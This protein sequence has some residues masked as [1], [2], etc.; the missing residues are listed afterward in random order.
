MKAWIFPGQGAQ[1]IGMGEALFAAFPD[2]TAA[3]DAVLGFSIADLCLAGPME[4]LTETANTQPALYVVNA[5]A[6]LRQ[7]NEVG[8]PPD[9]L[10]GH[11]VSEYVALFAAGV[12]GFEDGL[13]LVARRGALMGEARGGGMAAVLGLDAAQV[14]EV[15]QRHGLTDVFAANYN[16]PRQIVV[17][18][19]RAAV[20][21]AEPLFLEA[22][23]SHYRVLTVGGAF[24]TPFMQPARDAFAPFI[25]DVPLAPPRIP[26]LSNV[27]AR[28]HADDPESIRAR[29]IDQITAPVRWSDS[30]RYLLA[31]GV[32]F[33]D[34]TE[35]GPDG[36]PV[37]KP[38]VKRTELEA[39]ALSA[40]EL[41]R[42]D[43]PP[44]PVEPPKPPEPAPV[45]SA[46]P[47]VS[48]ER[49]GS[50]AF[51]EAFGV[52][53]PYV[54]GAMYRGIASVDVVVRMARA[55]ML[56][57]FGTGG[58]SIDQVRAAITAIRAAIP[59]GAAFGVNVLAHVNRPQLEED[60]VDLLLEQGV[61]VAEASAF[62]EVT[63]AL[64]RYRARG[65]V[66]AGG[67]R[68]EARNRIM[69][70]VS[71]PDVAAQ[72]LSPAPERVVE[73]LV[74]QG[75]LSADEAA[76]LRHVPMADAIT[77]EA[78][79][80]GHTDQRMP[81]AL[82]PAVLRERDRAQAR[83][84][85]FGPLHLGAGGGIGTPEAVAAAFMLGA[86]YVLTGSINQCTV[87]AATSD[88]VKDML[89]GMNVHDTAY[90]PS[91]AMFELGSRV[92]VLKKGL[93][94]PSR[95][96]KLVSLYHRHER[97]EDIEP[98]LSR[99]IQDKY[100]RRSFADIL[101]DLKDSLPA[102][103]AERAERMPKH[104]MALVFRRY[105][106]DTSHW[107]ITGDLARRVDFQVHCGPALGAFNQWVAGTDLEDWKAR[108]VDGI[109]E[110]L[111]D[112]TAALLGRRFS[113]LVG[114]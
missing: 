59:A 12:V 80:G 16:T 4:R 37:V 45:R 101:S 98:A 56:S 91:G 9:V 38:M 57:F 55:G 14:E 77:V 33:A 65:L 75:T 28:P 100:L 111:L 2:Q 18:G 8:T 23:A 25:A 50:R 34:V 43:A 5:L 1:R 113:A 95:A 7:L 49:L 89:A 3:A 74:A 86:D 17:S 107:A 52:R 10:M 81:F 103:E 73:R 85:R 27:T 104:R 64:V 72:F 36:P 63:P 29:M 90:A 83:F 24:H 54:S 58:L 19:R 109:A 84:P 30:I 31:K 60:M 97:L 47:G 20:E 114:A 61:R 11:S 41:A 93:F 108:H 88:A 53:H 35:I 110:R 69:A 13:R 78:D 32:T 6:Y 99:Q 70:K 39:G 105:F 40:D 46:G 68:V 71:R 42:E 76:L 66:D 48:V 21:A 22:G 79:S 102:D 51:R 44:A 15:I 82:V 94:F 62:M 96:E 112:E 92:Q 87:E 106:Q 67:G 26:V